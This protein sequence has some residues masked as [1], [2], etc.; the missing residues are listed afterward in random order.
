MF[1]SQVPDGY[2]FAFEE[3]LFNKHEHRITQASSGWSDVYLLDEK[4]QIVRASF[5]YHVDNKK[6]SSPFQATFGGIDFDGTLRLGLLSEFVAFINLDLKS[7]GVEFTRITLA[8]Q[9]YDNEKFILL[10][11]ALADNGYVL[12]KSEMAASISIGQ[13]PFKDVIHKSRGYKLKQAH[14]AGYEFKVENLSSFPTIYQMLT[15]FRKERGQNLSMSEEQLAKVIE[16]IPSHFHFFS[17][18]DEDAMIA[19][20]ICISTAS[21]ILYVFYA[22][23][24]K[25]YDNTSPTVMLYEGIYKYAQSE[26]FRLID[27]GTSHGENGTDNNLLEFKRFIG[28]SFGLKTTF[29]INYQ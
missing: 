22:G 8:P 16:A 28:C 18:V 17:L 29:Q 7:K 10:F 6:A 27:F 1:S 3:Y 19:S 25:A 20:T 14:I 9:N 5:H 4:K 24:L 2:R 21:N 12:E 23:H 11:Q 15:N 26:G 13:L